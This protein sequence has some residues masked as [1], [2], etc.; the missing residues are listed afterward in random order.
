MPR[1]KRY[2]VW[3]NGEPMRTPAQIETENRLQRQAHATRRK[4]NPTLLDTLDTSTDDP[5]YA[6][7]VTNFSIVDGPCKADPVTIKA[8]LGWNGTP[9][10]SPSFVDSICGKERTLVARTYLTT[11][12]VATLLDQTAEHVARLCKRGVIPG[13]QW[14]GEGGLWRIPTGEF[15]LYLARCGCTNAELDA[16]RTRIQ[17]MQEMAEDAERAS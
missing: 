13:R 10:L 3:I 16:Y 2:P 11:E 17:A 15:D 6:L 1:A 4:T 14:S 9:D 8:T 12:Q 7:A 5:K